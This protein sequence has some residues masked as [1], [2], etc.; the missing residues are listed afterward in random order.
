MLGYRENVESANLFCE[1]RAYQARM[2]QNFISNFL[3][4][5]REELAL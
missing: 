2:A 3:V 5:R 4:T 1:A